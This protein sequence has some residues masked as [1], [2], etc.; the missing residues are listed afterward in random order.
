MFF[1]KILMF[2]SYQKSIIISHFFTGAAEHMG[3]SNLTGKRLKSVKQSAISAHLLE[4]DCSID[5]D[6]FEILA[7]DENKLRPAP[8][9][10]NYQV[11]FIKTIWLGH[12]LIDFHC[13]YACCYEILKLIKS[14]L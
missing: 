9:K 1:I 10:Q 2:R 12:L 7:S 4:C 14:V 5:F 13:T 8:D 6:H 3:I 11:I